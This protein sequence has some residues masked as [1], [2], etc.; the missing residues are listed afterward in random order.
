MLL[1]NVLSSIRCHRL[2]LWE[3]TKRD[4]SAKYKG[5]YLGIFWAILMPLGTLSVYSYVFGTVFNSRWS[6]AGKADVPFPIVLFA[7]LIVF[8]FFAECVNRAPTL[9]TSS[10]NLVKK[11]V[12]PVVILPWMAT[13]TAFINSLISVSILLV[14]QL[15]FIGHIPVTALL[16]PIVLLPVA[17]V[18]LGVG[19]FLASLGVY[20]RDIAQMVG[21]VTTT[22]LFLTPIFYPPGRTPS[23]LDAFTSIN[24]LATQVQSMRAILLWGEVPSLTSFATAL[25]VGW[26]VAWLGL[27]WFTKTSDGFADVL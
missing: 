23:T 25:V 6:M 11:S 9:V 18:A 14:S 13:F 24:P 17:L 12:F 5:S 20:V 27:I 21:L 15:I 3:M 4:I 22:L 26:A 7:G 16:F 1:I 2:L 8:N 10:P 19:W